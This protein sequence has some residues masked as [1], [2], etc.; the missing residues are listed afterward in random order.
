MFDVTKTK[1]QRPAA[2]ASTK[3]EGNFEGFIISFSTKLN[4]WLPPTLDLS[5]D[6]LNITPILDLNNVSNVTPAEKEICMRAVFSLAEESIP[7]T[8]ESRLMQF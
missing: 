1:W 8:A 2:A 7:S 6:T 3:A 5:L 4:F